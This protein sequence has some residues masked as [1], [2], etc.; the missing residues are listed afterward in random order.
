[1]VGC[2]VFVIVMGVDIGGLCVWF[3]YFVIQ[4]FG[5]GVIFGFF[6]GFKVQVYLI[7][8]VV[9]V[10]LVY[11]WIDFV[12]IGGGKIQYLV[13]YVGCVGLYGIV[14]RLIDMDLYG[15]NFLFLFVCVII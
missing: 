1:M 9:V 15:G 4:F 10:G 14:G 2:E 6:V 8:G 7:L 11:Q 5:F 3:D 12:G 13:F